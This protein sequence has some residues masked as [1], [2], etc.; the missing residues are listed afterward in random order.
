MSLLVKICGL[1]TPE[2]LEASL[3]A[4]A[5]MVG[6]VFFPP[7]PRHVDLGR[8]RELGRQVRRRALKVALTVDADDATFANIIDALDPQMLQLHGK[9]SVARVR[10]IKQRFGLPVMKALP[11]ETVAD[12]A[13]LPGYAAAADR[14]LFDARAPKDATRPG[15]LGR[16][17]DWHLLERVALAIPFMVSG[18]L[19]AGNVAEALRVT[20]AGGVDVSSGVESV[21]GVKDITRIQAFVAAARAAAGAAPSPLTAS[22]A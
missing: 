9:E 12:L 22:R 13:V 18:G 16:P 7:S 20:G 19:D 17:F 5:D 2:T 21:P 4:G 10:D 11:V 15:G 3:A 6:F 8:A 1:S 14:I